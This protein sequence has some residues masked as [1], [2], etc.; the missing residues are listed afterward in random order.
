MRTRLLRSIRS[1]IAGS[2]G[3]LVLLGLWQAATMIGVV[4]VALLPSPYTTAT[5]L[6][7]LFASGSIWPDIRSTLSLVA[8]GYT[9]AAIIGTVLGVGM[10][11]FAPLHKA[12]ITVVDFFRSIPVTML[13][14][15]F[16]FALGVGFA[17]KVGMIFTASVWVIA[18]HSSYGVLQANRVRAQMATLYGATPRQVFFLIRLFDALPQTMIGLR[19]AISYAA[20]VAL[21]CEMFMGAK[22]G[23]GQRLTEAYTMYAMPEMYALIVIAGTIGYLLNRAFV[24]VERR[25]VH[26][27]GR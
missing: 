24:L 2:L 25:L 9:A 22:H 14:P 6:W 7:I 26:W 11:G 27:G 5:R 4:N 8:I 23:I 18:L 15:V 20:I 3:M 21:L 10:G 17:S 12:M 19:I 16:V 1:A 13:Y